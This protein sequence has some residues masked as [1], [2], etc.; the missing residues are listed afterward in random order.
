MHLVGIGE[1]IIFPAELYNNSTL[2]GDY[3][4]VWILHHYKQSFSHIAI[5]CLDV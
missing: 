2:F 1:L 4:V 5:R 3:L